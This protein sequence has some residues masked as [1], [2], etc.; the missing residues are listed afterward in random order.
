MFLLFWC[1]LVVVSAVYIVIP[2]T[3]TLT[4]YFTISAQKASWISS[5]FSV[6]YA[7]GFLVFAPLSQKYGK[8]QIIVIGFL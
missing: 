3:D 5:I 1:A 7:F 2:I 8:K 6:F 4:S